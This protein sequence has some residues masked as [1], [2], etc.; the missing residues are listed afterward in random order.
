MIGGHSMLTWADAVCINQGNP[1]ERTSQVQR[2][3]K[4]YSNAEK[5]IAYL[6][7]DPG[8]DRDLCPLLSKIQSLWWS[9][10]AHKFDPLQHHVNPEDCERLGLPPVNDLAWKKFDKILE[11]ECFLAGQIWLT[12]YAPLTQEITSVRS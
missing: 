8:N 4:I 5:V 7:E 10:S 3:G 11:L 1:E 2:M 6:G 12:T 9:L